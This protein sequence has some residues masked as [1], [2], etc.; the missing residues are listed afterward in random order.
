MKLPLNRGPLLQGL[1][2][3]AFFTF[4]V[5]VLIPAYVPRPAFIPGFAPPPDM[6]PRTVSIIGAVIGL[7]TVVGALFG[8]GVPA[9]QITTDGASSKIHFL[10]FLAVLLC[11]AGFLIL[12]PLIGFLLSAVV[13]IGVAIFLA[14]E[15]KHWVWAAGITLVGPF[16]L[17]SFFHSVLGT[18]FPV[19]A[20]T[21][22]LGF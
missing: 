1:A 7:I 3:I 8:R 11:F 6:W 18:Q 9:E 19:G 21:K 22:S 4:V 15:R 12:V 17:V 10:R 13:L 5:L 2:I 14:G 16:L 20:L